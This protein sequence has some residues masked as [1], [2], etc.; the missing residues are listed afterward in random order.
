MV[1][2]LADDAQIELTWTTYTFYL[3]QTNF[4]YLFARNSS[5]IPTLLNWHKGTH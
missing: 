1:N 2:V 5:Q 3:G 4:H